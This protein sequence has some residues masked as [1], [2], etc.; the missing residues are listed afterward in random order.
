MKNNFFV[1]K[2][3]FK[4]IFNVLMQFYCCMRQRFFVLFLVYTR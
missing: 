3:I 4:R 1:Y 2:Y